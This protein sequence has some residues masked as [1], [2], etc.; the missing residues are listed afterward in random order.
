MKKLT[1]R[2]EEILQFISQYT[3]QHEY[4][5][6]YQEIAD[7]FNLASKQG[8]VRHLVALERK[9]YITRGDTVARS[10]RIIHPQYMPQ[11]DTV[12]VPLVDR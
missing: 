4:A 11:T 2:Q 10:I 8:V 1:Q 12:H 6:T 5:P 7:A 9:G 3:Q